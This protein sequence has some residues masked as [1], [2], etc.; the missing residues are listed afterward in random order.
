MLQETLLKLRKDIIEKD[1]LIE[2]L[3][4][5]I[6]NIENNINKGAVYMNGSNLTNN[7]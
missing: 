1:K 7:L 5:K 2:E 6:N 4:N 3:T